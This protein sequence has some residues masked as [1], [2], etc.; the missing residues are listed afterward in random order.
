VKLTFVIAVVEGSVSLIDSVDVL[1]TT[2]VVGANVLTA[3][4]GA[5]EVAGCNCT[6]VERFRWKP[7]TDCPEFTAEAMSTLTTAA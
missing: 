2:M 1:P 4:G 3:V 5:P 6:R 7:W